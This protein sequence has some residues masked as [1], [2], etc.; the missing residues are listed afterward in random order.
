MDKLFKL[1]GSKMPN[2]GEKT[3]AESRFQFAFNKIKR[4]NNE[5]KS[6]IN[7]LEDKL[8]QASTESIELITRANTF[9]SNTGSNSDSLGSSRSTIESYPCYKELKIYLHE[10]TR[11][12]ELEF[13]GKPINIDSFECGI[14]RLVQSFIPKL[15]KCEYLADTIMLNAHK[16]DYDVNIHKNGYRT[17]VKAF[18]KCCQNTLALLKDLNL[19][20]STFL[21]QMKTKY[22]QQAFSN[23]IKELETYIKLFE[24]FEYLLEIAVEMQTLTNTDQS[25][26]INEKLIN[27]ELERKLLLASMQNP[28]AYFGRS[29]AFQFSNSLK[30]PLTGCAIALASYNDGYEAFQ[31]NLLGKTAKILFSSSKYVINPELRA[32]KLADIMK[33]ANVEFCKAFWQLTETPLVHMSSNF[34]TPNLPVNVV[35]ALDPIDLEIDMTNGEKTIIKAPFQKNE[36]TIRILSDEFREGMHDLDNQLLITCLNTGNRSIQTRSPNL[37]LH[38]HGGGFIAHSSKSHEI[39]LKTWCKD[40]NVPIVSI[41]YSLA[42]EYPFPKSSEECFYVYAWCLINK[43]LLGWTGEKIICVG[44]SAGGVLVTNITQ[45]A[46]EAQIRIPDALVP[47]YAPFLLA[48][49]LSPSRLLSVMDPLL[50]LGILWR[51]LAG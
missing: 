43:D 11:D 1:F 2:M 29:C 49:S 3:A 12:Y 16:Y 14:N 33:N 7:N 28:E 36:L 22:M 45:R 44:D 5:N 27:F 23:I 26:F 9:A 46:I 18:D 20:K 31:N 24:N 30:M 47:I 8:N 4:L 42:P 38:A 10:L 21:Y 13:D 37:I 17:L 25:L 51:C 40:L 50:N 41:D 39:Y 15:N 19:N 34:I 48:Y 35:K 6:N 32:E